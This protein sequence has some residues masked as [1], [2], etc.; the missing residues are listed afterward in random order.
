MYTYHV[1]RSS[2]NQQYYWTLEAGNSEPIAW[3]GETYINKTDC[4]NGLNLFKTHAPTAPVNDTTATSAR[5]TSTL[6]FELF[7]DVKGEYRWRFQ[8]GNNRIIGVSGEGYIT[9]QG[10]LDAIGR[11]KANA[12]RA[13]IVDHTQT[14]A[15]LY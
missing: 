1:R 3:S 11:V 8:A 10:C 15:T 12:G 5:R 13:P 14:V 4:L 6:E 7:K 2:A 9:R